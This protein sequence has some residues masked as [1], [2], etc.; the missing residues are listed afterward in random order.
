MIYG[1]HIFFLVIYLG[2]LELRGPCFEVW[3]EGSFHGEGGLDVGATI[4]RERGRIHAWK[5]V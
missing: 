4:E 5:F 2:F 1:S 3:R